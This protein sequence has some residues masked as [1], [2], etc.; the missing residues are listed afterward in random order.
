M[1]GVQHAMVERIAHDIQNILHIAGVVRRNHISKEIA[2]NDNACSQRQ[3]R[4][5]DRPGRQSQRVKHGDHAFAR[6]ARE[7][8]RRAQT[9]RHRQGQK[10]DGRRDADQRGRHKTAA[11]S[12]RRQLVEQI[13]QNDRH[14]QRQLHDQH[15]QADALEQI[16]EQQARHGGPSR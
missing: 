6:H 7:F 5:T 13:R 11:H 14:R 1:R 9:D 10:S 8:E 4:A 16:H 15:A 3:R 12:G 2:E